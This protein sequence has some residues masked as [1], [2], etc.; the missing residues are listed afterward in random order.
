MWLEAARNYAGAEEWAR[1]ATALILKEL[2][3]RAVVRTMPWPQK[4]METQLPRLELEHK[5]LIP[6]Y[7]SSPL[8]T[9]RARVS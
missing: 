5:D 7:Q 3:S 9:A 4:E 6:W 8:E 1:K 2:E